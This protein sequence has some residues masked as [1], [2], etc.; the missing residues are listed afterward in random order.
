[1]NGAERIALA[2]GVLSLVAAGTPASPARLLTASFT[3]GCDSYRIAV[4][5]EGLEQPNPIVSYNITLAPRSGESIIIT[6]SFAVSPQKD[7]SFRETI[8]ESW[9]Q[10]GYA[11]TG[12]YRLSG[13]AVLLSNL[14]LLHTLTI[15]FSQEKLNCGLKKR[16]SKSWSFSYFAADLFKQNLFCPSTPYLPKNHLK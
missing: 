8:H 12:N 3:G 9:K 7:G 5:G 10:F 16:D 6:D 4:A 11:L 2:V 13:S 1:V 14:T 15:K